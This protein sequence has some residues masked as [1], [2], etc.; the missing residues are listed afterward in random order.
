MKHINSLQNL[1]IINI[2]L[3]SL[4]G[5]FF[6]SCS[7]DKF[8]GEG[9]YLLEQVKIK[10]DS[11]SVDANNFTQYIRQKDN[12]RWFSLIKIPLS[13]YSLSGKDT[14]KWINRTLQNMGEKPVI[15]DTLQAKLTKEDLRIALNNIGYLN[16]KVDIETKI[17][18]KRLKATYILHP[19]SPF[20]I[21]KFN[22]DIQDSVIAN[23]LKPHIKFIYKDFCGKQFNV[24]KLDEERKRLTNILNN[25]GYYKFNKDYITYSADSTYKDN[26]VTLTLHIAPYYNTNIH[27]TT[28]HPRFIIS[29]VDITGEDSIKLPLKENIINDNNLIEKGKYF[30]LNDLQETY[31]NF[32]RLGAIRFTN[33]EFKE[34]PKEKGKNKLLAKLTLIPNKINTISFQPEG[35]N[36]AG[37]LGAAGVITY[38]NRNLFKGSELLSIELRSAFEAITGLEGYENKNYEEYSLQTK[39]EFPRFLAPFLKHKFRRQNKS[40]TEVSLSWSLQNRPEFHRRVFSAAWRYLWTNEDKHISFNFDA[41][42]LNYIYMPWISKT[43]KKDYLDDVSN[44]NAILRYNYSDL[45]IMKLG[46]G[47]NYNYNNTAIKFQIETAGNFLNGLSLFM[48]FNKN[49]QGQNKFFNIAYAQYAKLDFAYTHVFKFDTHNNLVMHTDMGI[50]Y[51]YGNSN[52]LPFEKRYISGGA[53]SVR[54]W[55]V[56]ELGPGRF[57][58][59]DGRIDFINQTGDLKLNFNLEYRTHLFWKLDG[60]AF[61]D[62]GNIWTLRNYE[63]QKG[64]QFTLNT[65]YKELA[66]AYGLGIR[67]NFDYLILRLDMGMKAINP[68]FNTPKE[69]FPLICPKFK[70]DFAFHFAVGLPF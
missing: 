12:S 7:T 26:T 69:H 30:S 9:Q 68:V 3:L 34:L 70:R 58:G 1:H 33:I 14:T 62:L 13:T 65:F 55:N 15:Y 50:A 51:P 22:Y 20:K 19:G 37:N 18:K 41:T 52:I 21:K 6:F 8:I 44:R 38:Q 59:K 35:T 49:S 53:N 16:A 57:N 45:F 25:I 63:E 64:G 5:I 32:A 11:N 27:S 24:M 28:L 48:K 2:T 60:A 43:F 61:I 66:A 56:R 47:F 39:L 36:T 29:K 40:T 4:L 17:E 54:G 31:K 46:F 23:I 10:A 67:L 42:D